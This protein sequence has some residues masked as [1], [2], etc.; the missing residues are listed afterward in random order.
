MCP[1]LSLR[2]FDEVSTNTT[3]DVNFSDGRSYVI[4][5]GDSLLS[6]RT[7]STGGKATHAVVI[8]E[9]V[10]ANLGSDGPLTKTVA[11]LEGQGLRVDVITFEGGEARKNMATV[12]DI[13]QQLYEIPGVDRKTLL[14]AVGGGVIGD[15]VGFVAA[16]YLRGL[17]F[18]QVPT[19]LLAM[20]DSS[21]GG[22]TGVDFVQGKNLVG[23]FIQPSAVWIDTSVLATLPNRE[24][25]AGMAEVIK[26][27]IISDR[28]ILDLCKALPTETKQYID[29][30]TKS[31]A[32]KASVVIEDEHEITGARATLNFGHT[33]GHALEG[34]TGYQRYKHGEAVAIGMVSACHIGIAAGLTP[35]IILNTLLDTLTSIGLPTTLP[36]D[37]TDDA[38]IA[39]TSRD[40][41]AAAGVARYVI[42]RDF[43]RMELHTLQADVVKAGLAQHRSKE[44]HNV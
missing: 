5:I 10:I 14:V 34:L 4:S 31:C 7:L 25:A 33:I 32:I 40:K 29:I 38:L 28:D 41:K 2:R 8:T 1:S 18:V 30:V 39:L 22:K 23:A 21:V 11:N 20:V 35:P 19:T 37:I 6:E 16:I 27:G 26:Y 36:D 3:V 17:P 13:M 43:G 42:A 12:M 15:I 24:L 9:N 44:G